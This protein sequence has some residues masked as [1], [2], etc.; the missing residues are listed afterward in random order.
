MA[1]GQILGTAQQGIIADNQRCYLQFVEFAQHFC[2]SGSSGSAICTRAQVAK[3]GHLQ[4]AEMPLQRVQL[5]AHSICA[6]TY[7]DKC[8]PHAFQVRKFRL[9]LPQGH[10]HTAFFQPMN[11]RRRYCLHT[12]LKHRANFCFTLFPFHTAHS[13]CIFLVK[14]L[15]GCGEMG[16]IENDAEA[17]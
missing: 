12:S 5:L 4:I 8:Q 16:N 6:F 3:I 9:I 11:Q 13:R 17:N 15:S 2:K 1:Q 14:S 10:S 7:A